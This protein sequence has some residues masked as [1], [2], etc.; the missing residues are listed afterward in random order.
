MF[1]PI[2][3]TNLRDRV[4]EQVRVAIIEGRLKPGDHVAEVKLTAQ[5][6]V[7]RTPVREALILLE[8]EGLV[9]AAPNRGAFV[10]VFAETDVDTIFSMRTVLEN[11]AAERVVGTLGTADFMGLE[12]LVTQQERFIEADDFKG[13]RST[14]MA[15]HQTLV[16]RAA[17]PLLERG[18]RELVAQIA[19]LLYLR[20]EAI[21][22]YDEQRAVQDH[23]AILGALRA[24]DLEAVKAQHHRINAR[25]A[26]ECRFAVRELAG[27]R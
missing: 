22:D 18:W 14:D 16:E 13:V 8:R 9:V 19:A 26:A 21:R 10:R 23:R 27:S 4:V 2:R 11:F 24:G 5:L 7:S 17:H 6:G 20:A 15:F 12:A 3:T 25:V 1:A